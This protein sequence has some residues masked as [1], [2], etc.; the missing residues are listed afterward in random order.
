MDAK[1]LHRFSHFSCRTQQVVTS[2]TW[3]GLLIEQSTLSADTKESER[4]TWWVDIC[5]AT[6]EEVS[7]VCQALSIH[8]LTAE[9]IAT[10]EPREK[11]EAFRNYYLIS[12]QTLL[13]TDDFKS[14]RSLKPSSSIPGSAGFYI[15][16]FKN[17]TVTFSP[18]GCHH[19]AR[20]RDRIRRTQDTHLVSSDWICYALIDEIIDDFE[21]YMRAAEREADAIE[22]QVF[23]ARVDDVKALIPQLD[24]LRKSITQLIRCLT[25]K[26]DVL[27]GFVKRCQAKDRNPM[28]PD[29]DLLVYLGD[30]QDHLVTTL[31]SLSHFDEIVGRSQSNFLAQLSVNNIRLSYD[32]NAVLSKV[33]ILATIFVP[34]HMVTGL[35]G[36]NVECKGITWQDY[37][38]TAGWSA[39]LENLAC[40]GTSARDKGRVAPKMLILTVSV[41][42]SIGK[43]RPRHL[44]WPVRQ[45]F[46]SLQP[47][48]TPIGQFANGISQLQDKP[49]RLPL[50]LPYSQRGLPE[51]I[52]HVSRVTRGP[53]ARA[54]TSA[55]SGVPRGVV[56]NGQN[57]SGAAID[58]ESLWEMNAGGG[59]L[60]IGEAVEWRSGAPA[61]LGVGKLSR[62]TARKRGRDVMVIH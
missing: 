54:M 22:D 4:D 18:S 5:D 11:I 59:G 28:F 34:L 37:I 3:E 23:I 12:F 55:V 42:V 38:H 50:S 31:T 13:P 21:P 41:I 52:T 35:F 9:D 48:R 49:V 62:E 19:I 27:S 40:S 46:P 25:G 2:S 6:E 53:R 26:Y 10:R 60:A 61:K 24:S 36:M 56:A 51:R 1:G 20:V 43:I 33:T 16:V 44:I 32:V 14:S 58:E 47:R 17:A 29:G 39:I 7:T 57:Q 30:V 15:L 45:A 8:P